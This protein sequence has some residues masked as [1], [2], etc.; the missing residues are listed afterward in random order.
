MRREW[1]LSRA[2]SGW[3]AVGI[4]LV[5]PLMIVLYSFIGT[6][7]FAIFVY[8]TIRPVYTRLDNWIEH[9]NVTATITLLVVVLPILL[10]VGY[11]LLVSLQQL[12]QLLQS[13]NP[14]QYQSVLQSY[15]SLSGQFDTPRQLV[16]SVVTGNPQQIFR[17]LSDSFRIITSIL[18]RLFLLLAFTFYLLRDDDK[19]AGQLRGTFSDDQEAFGGSK[20]VV[21]EY[22]IS[23]DEDF[24]TLYVGN[25]VL[26]L[27]IGALSVPTY[28]L[29]GV[30]AP[31]GSSIPSPILL[32][33]RHHYRHPTQGLR[34]PHCSRCRPRQQ[35]QLCEYLS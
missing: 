15:L 33:M 32:V 3:G 35:S 9:P 19:I 11:A 31:S 21:E 8:Y 17:I 24:L 20:S 29:F 6:F 23:V 34:P 2:Q 18:L 16:I 14:K 26:V 1:S 30:F 7:V 22:M 4:A 27:V 10:V 12:G 28:Y 25:A 13:V 5:I